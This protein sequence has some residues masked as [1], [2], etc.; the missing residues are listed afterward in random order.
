MAKTPLD[1]VFWLSSTPGTASTRGAQPGRHGVRMA[2]RPQPQVALQKR[3]EL[4]GHEAHLGGQLHVHFPQEEQA[5][6]GFRIERHHQLAEQEPVLG[7][8]EGEDVHAGIAG[9]SPQ[10]ERQRCAAALASRAPSMCSFMPLAWTCVGD[11]AHLFRGVARAQ[12][13]GLG[14]GD[15]QRLG[16]VLVTPAPGLTVDEFRGQFAVRRGN[17]QQLDAA[18]PLRRAVLVHV[19]VGC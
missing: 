2:G 18:D 5:V 3:D 10:R 14:D 4:G 16:A 13:R 17:L 6:G 19:D 7:P 1:S 8:A 11:R 9:E 15:G 12:F